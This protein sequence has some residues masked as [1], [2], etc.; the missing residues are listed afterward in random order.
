MP[1]FATG[2]EEPVNLG[3]DLDGV[4]DEATEFF[5][6]L[7]RVWPGQVVVIS[8]RSDDEKARADLDQLGIRYDD[9]VLV[10]TAG[11][12]CHSHDESVWFSSPGCHFQEHE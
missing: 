4:L 11:L 3:L 5:S 6:L 12:T 1:N 2:R 9:L 10:G 7:T 8:Y